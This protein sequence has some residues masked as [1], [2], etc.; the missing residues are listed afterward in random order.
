MRKARDLVAAPSILFK[1]C[2]D[3]NMPSLPMKVSAICVSERSKALARAY[4][5]PEWGAK[6]CG[7]LRPD[8]AVS[9]PKHH[10]I[11]TRGAV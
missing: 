3:S 9:K 7:A 6:D 8:K 11:G 5:Q 10:R 4:R 1:A 2:G